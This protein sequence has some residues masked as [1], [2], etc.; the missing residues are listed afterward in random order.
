LHS[1]ESALV[2]TISQILVGQKEPQFA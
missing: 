2:Q 1:A